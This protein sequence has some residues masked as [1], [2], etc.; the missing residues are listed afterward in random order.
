MRKF[1]TP[2]QLREADAEYAQ[3]TPGSTLFSQ[4]VQAFTRW[5]SKKSSLKEIGAYCEEIS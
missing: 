2:Q 4:A 3:P 1:I 5:G